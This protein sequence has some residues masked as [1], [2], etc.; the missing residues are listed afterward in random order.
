MTWVNFATSS[1]RHSWYKY[2]T[3]FTHSL[4]FSTWF[5]FILVTNAHCN[6]NDEMLIVIHKS[7][8]WRWFHSRLRFMRCVRE[9]AFIRLKSTCLL[10]WNA[11]WSR[12]FQCALFSSRWRFTDCV[13]CFRWMCWTFVLTFKRVHK[14]FSRSLF[15]FF[16][17]IYFRSILIE[18]FCMLCLCL[19]DVDSFVALLN[20]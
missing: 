3:S 6:S 14:S 11:C 1:L 15:H 5:I 17:S 9:I 19:V 4:T 16:F 7:M 20:L 12:R 13:V 8:R 18:V 10:S 2:S